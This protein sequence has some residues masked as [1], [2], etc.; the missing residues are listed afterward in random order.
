MTLP[1]RW[2]GGFRVQQVVTSRGAYER[3]CGRATRP[4]AALRPAPD[5]R[6]HFSVANRLRFGA[7]CAVH[8]RGFHEC[9]LAR[10]TVD[11]LIDEQSRRDGACR[12][13]CGSVR[14]YRW[15]MSVG[16]SFYSVLNFEDVVFSHTVGTRCSRRAGSVH[17]TEKRFCGDLGE[18]RTYI[19]NRA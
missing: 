12:H 13:R 10:E 5:E 17:G 4:S 7:K 19:L 9:G 6:A 14:G 1:C 8:G 2:G 11:T 15:P 18:R 16:V 3:P